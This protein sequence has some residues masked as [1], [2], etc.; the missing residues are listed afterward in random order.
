MGN[1][2]ERTGVNRK[3]KIKFRELQEKGIKM[4]ISNLKVKLASEDR[5]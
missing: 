1:N 2:K 3:K 4:K 5:T